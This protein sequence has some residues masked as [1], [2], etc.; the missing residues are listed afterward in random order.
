M[1]NDKNSNDGTDNDGA[2]GQVLHPKLFDREDHE[3]IEVAL[4]LL[5][6][7]WTTA[8]LIELF[9][10]RKRTAQLLKS[11]PGLSAKTLSERLRTLQ[12]LCLISRTVYPE[13]PPRVEYELTE[14]GLKLFD[15]MEALKAIGQRFKSA[16]AAR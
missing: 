6:P 2:I 7:R 10:G 8:I 9:Y 1:L 13:V 14:E 15:A 4:D 11:L 3:P 12:E 5:S 16:R